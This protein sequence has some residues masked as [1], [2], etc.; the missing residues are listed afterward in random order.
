[1][2]ESWR[3]LYLDGV[4]WKEVEPVG[5]YDVV[6]DRLNV[7]KFAS[8]TTSALRLVVKC[9]PGMSAGVLEWL[10]E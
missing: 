3:L 1:M 4:D 2:P 5:E 8:V 9:Q 7:L 6:K 10:V